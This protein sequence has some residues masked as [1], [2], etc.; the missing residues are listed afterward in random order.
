MFTSRP[1]RLRHLDALVAATILVATQ[2]A[3]AYAYVDPGS[4]SIVITAILGGLAAISYSAR[5]YLGR[6]KNFI[7]RKKPQ[8]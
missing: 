2:V 8:K 6:A 3:P 7:L 1:S 5:M 4:I